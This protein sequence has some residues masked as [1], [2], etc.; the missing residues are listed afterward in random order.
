MIRKAIGDDEDHHNHSNLQPKTMSFNYMI[1]S[2]CFIIGS[3]ITFISFSFAPQSI[4]AAMSGIQFVSN[5]VFAKLIHDEKLT[6]PHTQT[7]L[8]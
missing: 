4:L 5:I 3:I 2:S 1:G 8:C 7:E 6:T